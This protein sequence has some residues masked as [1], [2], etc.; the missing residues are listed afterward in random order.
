MPALDL[1]LRMW[2]V[3]RRVLKEH[4]GLRIRYLACLTIPA[5][6]LLRSWSERGRDKG[7]H[8]ASG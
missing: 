2:K 7:A 3:Q 4:Y 1:L 8:G 6:E 5:R